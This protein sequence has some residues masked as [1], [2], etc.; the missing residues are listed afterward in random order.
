MNL[1]DH[2]KA[3]SKLEEEL[4]K[5]L[6]EIAKY[7]AT[8]D[9]IALITRRVIGSQEDY[10]GKTFKSYSTKPMLTNRTALTSR[11]YSSVAGSKKKRRDLDWVTINGH[12]LFE[13]K[14]G[15]AEYRNLL[16]HTNKNKSFELTGEM[17][18]KFGIL[19][20]STSNYITT[21]IMGGTNEASQMKIDANS[22]REG[23]SIIEASKK[24]IEIAE[25]SMQKWLE[26]VVSR[27]L[28]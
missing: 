11:A 2:I 18:R 20:V 6:P 27:N 16:G 26:D 21:V 7:V 25:K 22:E 4:E 5:G 14:G 17:W 9:L 23:V 28:K 8:N 15:Y 24:E 3:L 1:D 13:L 12:K 19:S 10:T